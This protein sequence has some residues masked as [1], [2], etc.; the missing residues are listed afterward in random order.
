M[1]DLPELC[2]RDSTRVREITSERIAQIH[3]R[4]LDDED[5]DEDEEEDKNDEHKQRSK[6]EKAGDLEAPQSLPVPPLS[7]SQDPPISGFLTC[8]SLLLLIQLAV[9]TRGT[10]VKMEKSFQRYS[11]SKSVPIQIHSLSVC[12]IFSF[13]AL[14][15]L[16]S[17]HRKILLTLI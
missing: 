16:I 9:V 10:L 4:D 6:D 17:E 12:A 11:N 7:G 13:L 15:Y 5:E 2:V 1:R 14:L 3:E 8:S